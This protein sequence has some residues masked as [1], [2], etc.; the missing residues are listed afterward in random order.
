VHEQKT[1]EAHAQR[2]GNGVENAFEEIFEHVGEAAMRTLAGARI[3]RPF[4]S[5]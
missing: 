2:D 4:S 5:S 3:A 1:H